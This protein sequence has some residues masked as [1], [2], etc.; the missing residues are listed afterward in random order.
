MNTNNRN[1]LKSLKRNT[2]K[3]DGNIIE[4]IL[5]DALVW[6]QFEIKNKIQMSL[7]IKIMTK[8][9][10]QDAPGPRLMYRKQTEIMGIQS[11]NKVT[12]WYSI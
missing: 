12:E 4:L 5:I 7:M 6:T 11:I 10:K 1:K 2:R 3:R 9:Q 8:K